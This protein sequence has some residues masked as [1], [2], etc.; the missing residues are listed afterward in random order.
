MLVI[1][2]IAALLFFHCL[3]FGESAFIAWGLLLLMFLGISV[4]VL[5]L[6]V[7]QKLGPQAIVDRIDIPLLVVPN[8]Y[9]ALLLLLPLFMGVIRH[10][11]IPGLSTGAKQA[12]PVV[13]GSLAVL[14]SM[15]LDSSLCLLLCLLCFALALPMSVRAVISPHRLATGVLLLFVAS[16]GTG[17]LWK[18]GQLPTSRIPV[19]DAALHQIAQSPLLGSSLDSFSNFYLAHIARTDYGDLITVDQRGMPWAHNLFLDVALSF[20]VPAALILL[21]LLVT[22]LLR[23]QSRL[24]F[25]STLLFITAAMVELTHLRIYTFATVAM[26]AGLTTAATTRKTQ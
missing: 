6:G 12:M 10:F 23:H 1:A 26:Y 13:I 20:G 25:Q 4:R 21:A 17:L 24:L 3:Y 11:P 2:L 15:V 18:F 16:A 22:I 14:T 8:D 7:V 19:W 5:M 9:A